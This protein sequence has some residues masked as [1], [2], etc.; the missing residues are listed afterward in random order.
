M[1]DTQPELRDDA[2]KSARLQQLAAMAV[3]TEDAR[4]IVRDGQPVYP[5]PMDRPLPEVEGQDVVDHGGTKKAQVLFN[6][7]RTRRNGVTIESRRG[8][9]IKVTA[10]QLSR[11]VE[12][13]GLKALE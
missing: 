1:V 10:E 12:L 13:G 7:W 9:V 5:G 4:P 2:A 3:G 11:G 6:L 8:D